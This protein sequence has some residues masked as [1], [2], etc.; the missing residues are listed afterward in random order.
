VERQDVEWVPLGPERDF[1][2]AK[3]KTTYWNDEHTVAELLPPGYA[4]CARVSPVPAGESGPP[5]DDASRSGAD[6]ALTRR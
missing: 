3:L 2:L 5:W 4:L 6:V 1:P